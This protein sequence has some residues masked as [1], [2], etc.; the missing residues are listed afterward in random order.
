[1]AQKNDPLSREEF[2]MAVGHAHQDA[3][4]TLAGGHL[5]GLLGAADG[6]TLGTMGF[7]GAILRV[8][9]P[10]RLRAKGVMCMQ[11]LHR[12]AAGAASA[13]N[14]LKGGAGRTHHASPAKR[15][16]REKPVFKP[17]G[18]LFAPTH[19]I[20]E[21]SVAENLI[22]T[23]SAGLHGVH[24]KALGK[25]GLFFYPAMMARRTPLARFLM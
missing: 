5:S 9:H 14:G 1:M 13:W 10:A 25:I 8:A 12:V 23:A 4:V 24:S 2:A 22:K 15:V 6:C 21:P 19:C 18:L 20:L 7:G 11:M 17:G 3:T 16:E